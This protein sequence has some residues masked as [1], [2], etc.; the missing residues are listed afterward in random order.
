MTPARPPGRVAGATLR[1][2]ASRS[3]WRR[4]MYRQSAPREHVAARLAPEGWWPANLLD[5]S[6]LFTI[7]WASPSGNGTAHSGARPP[8]CPLDV[9]Q[10]GLDTDTLDEQPSRSGAWVFLGSVH[11]YY[12]IRWRLHQTQDTKVC[13]HLN[14]RSLETMVTGPYRACRSR[15]VARIIMSRVSSHSSGSWR[16]IA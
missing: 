8:A 11:L 14:F 9:L 3:L 4:P 16:T 15:A 1:V 10:P 13:S 6:R 12:R 7:S 5:P 2:S